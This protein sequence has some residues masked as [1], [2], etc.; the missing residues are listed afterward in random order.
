[1][2]QAKVHI[3]PMKPAEEQVEA[4]VSAIKRIIPGS[5]DCII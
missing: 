2:E 5:R 1:M 4:V 3:D